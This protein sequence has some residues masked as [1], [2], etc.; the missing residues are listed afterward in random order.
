M[1][2]F[3]YEHGIADRLY[4]MATIKRVMDRA[5]WKALE[6]HTATDR[7]RVPY[8]TYRRAWRER[9]G[10]KFRADAIREASK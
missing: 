2:D 10:A 5:Y 1:S 9:F 7:P 8:G 6:L 3:G 4:R